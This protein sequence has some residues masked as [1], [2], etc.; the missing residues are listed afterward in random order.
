MAIAKHHR[1]GV[2]ITASAEY[3]EVGNDIVDIGVDR[4]ASTAAAAAAAAV[5]E[6]TSED[7]IIANGV[8]GALELALTSLLDDDGVLLVPRPGF[9]LYKVRSPQYT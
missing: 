7:V 3:N 9:P 1:S 4:A 2:S 5:V 6:V 8:S